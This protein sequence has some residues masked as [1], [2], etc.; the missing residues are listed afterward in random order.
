MNGKN[1]EKNRGQIGL[2]QTKEQIIIEDTYYTLKTGILL[3]S[4]KMLNI[5]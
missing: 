3:L 1:M 2:I 5:K 4:R